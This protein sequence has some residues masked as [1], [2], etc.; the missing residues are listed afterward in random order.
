ML[1]IIHVTFHLPVISATFTSIL[2]S[3]RNL[4]TCKKHFCFSDKLTKCVYHSYC[5]FTSHSCILH[6][7]I[8]HWSS[9]VITWF[10]FI[11]ISCSDRKILGTQ[12]CCAL[13]VGMMQLID[14]TVYTTVAIMQKKSRCKPNLWFS[15]PALYPIWRFQRFHRYN[16]HCTT[17]T[18]T[19]HPTAAGFELDDL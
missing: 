14:M 2:Y 18:H 3:E 15:L 11:I 19:P 1:W 4:P 16:N 7:L 9:I 5:F 12:F 10:L 6:F 17:Q 13:F 8:V